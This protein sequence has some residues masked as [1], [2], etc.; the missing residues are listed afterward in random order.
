MA[1]R[2]WWA[3]GLFAGALALL[4]LFLVVTETGHNTAAP[5]GPSITAGSDVKAW[6]APG[7]PPLSDRQAAALVVDQ[8]EQRPGNAAANHYI[9]TNAQ[10][11]AF[12]A[13]RDSEGQTT[14][15]FNPLFADVTGRPGLVHPST[16]DLIQWVS[17]KWGIPTDWIRAQVDYESG[18]HQTE[19]GDMSSVS[20]DWYA[21]YPPFSRIPGG[22]SVYESLGIAQ[23]KWTPSGSVG[24]GTE[25]LRWKSTAF[26]L[27]YYAATL[28]FYYDGDCHWCSAGYGPGQAWN[29]I[30]AW[31]EPQPWINRFARHYI[32]VVQGR[33]ADRNWA[34]PGF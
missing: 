6:S 3:L 20:R 9:P 5:T 29:A 12:H 13:A 26:N 28:R 32:E 16:D 4:A 18:W 8:P 24:A 17:H 1:S 10:L 11:A 30:G 21:R 7:T 31:Y 2:R 15:Q 27:D 22:T 33:L 34:Q 23:V 25:P 14:S 19:R